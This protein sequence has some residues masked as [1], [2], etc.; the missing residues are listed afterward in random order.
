[1][2]W[3]LS[4]SVVLTMCQYGRTPRTQD[5]TAP[6]EMKQE[7]PKQGRSQG[8][9][10]PKEQHSQR[11]INLLSQSALCQ[12]IERKGYTPEF[13]A[14]GSRQGHRMNASEKNKK[15]NKNY[16]VRPKENRKRKGKKGKEKIGE[17]RKEKRKEE[18][19][20]KRKN[21]R[22]GMEFTDSILQNYD[23]RGQQREER[24]VANRRCR[25][26]PPAL[27]VQWVI[28]IHLSVIH[29]INPSCQ[30]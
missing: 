24:R 6:E 27:S 8:S 11:G 10:S 23:T 2:P 16:N 19:K 22:C 25:L 30:V 5:H 3:G 7:N 28:P 17:K 21:V 26:L 1:M 13:S 18:R 4:F 29:P 14:H 20:K 9:S 15:R 12:P